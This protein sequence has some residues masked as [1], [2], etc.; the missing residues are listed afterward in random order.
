MPPTT[1]LVAITMLALAACAALSAAMLG[2][3]L[4][5]SAAQIAPGHKTNVSTWKH[6]VLFILLVNA[7]LLAH[8]FPHA[9]A[10]AALATIV[11]C[12]VA[13]GSKLPRKLQGT[14]CLLVLVIAAALLLLWL[15]ELRLESWKQ[16]SRGAPV[17]VD[18]LLFALPVYYVLR[19][20]GATLQVV[21]S[22]SASKP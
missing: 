12:P 14:A 20:V 9:L 2:R 19:Q 16:A 3:S 5:Q 1:D 6:A 18:L 4:A 11:V 15:Y 13:K 10:I 17:R 8:L 21:M 22:T 7:L